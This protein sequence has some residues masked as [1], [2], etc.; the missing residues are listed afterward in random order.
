LRHTH[1]SHLIDAGIDVV[2][3]SRR[4]EHGRSGHYAAS[5]CPSI[6]EEG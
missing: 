6:S 4:L 2:K 5:V 3:I 1:A